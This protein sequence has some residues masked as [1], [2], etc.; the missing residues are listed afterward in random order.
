GVVWI[1]RLLL[2]GRNPYTLAELP[3]SA[4]VYG[5]FYHV[6][7]YPLARVFGNG[8]GVHRLVSALAILGACALIYRLLRRLGVD[9]TFAWIGTLI[10]YLPK[11]FF[12]APPARRDG[13]GVLLCV[14]SIVWL[15]DEQVTIGHFTIGVVFALLA[16]MTKIYLAY[17]PFV[18]ATYLVVFGPR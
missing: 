13:L 16:L 1:T 15:M 18:M 14:A 9:E 4:N 2:E 5:I 7:V 6:V 3:E 17:P 12:P 8:F 11:I 10:F